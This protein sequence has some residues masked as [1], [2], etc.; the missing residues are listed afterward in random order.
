M[1]KK[2]LGELRSLAGKTP[3][4]TTRES[5][6]PE[7]Y[8]DPSDVTVNERVVA[9]LNHTIK[10]SLR[11]V[12]GLQGLNQLPES[13]YPATFR[14]LLPVGFK[15]VL[16]YVREHGLPARMACYRP[17]DGSGEWIYQ[18]GG[19]WKLSSVDERGMCFDQTFASKLDAEKAV[20]SAFR[21]GYEMFLS[22]PLSSARVEP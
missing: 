22:P 9:V 2:L 21:G 15:D 11:M 1:L 3:Y 12:L 13:S 17:P 10:S 19:E 16:E 20:L 6:G 14:E 5:Y 4:E 7:P 18:S 8:L